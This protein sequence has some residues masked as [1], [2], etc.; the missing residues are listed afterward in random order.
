MQAEEGSGDES[1]EAGGRK[2]NKTDKTAYYVPEDL[3]QKHD[4]RMGVDELQD[5]L[6][7]KEG[8]KREKE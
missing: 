1:D 8:R 7:K 2:R 4:W 3:K 6:E 5:R